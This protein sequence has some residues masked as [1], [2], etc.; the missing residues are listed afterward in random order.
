MKTE[1]GTRV[2]KARIHAGL[3]QVA[4]AKLAGMSQGTLGELEREGQGSSFTVALALHCGVDANW[5]ANG[6]GEML[7][8]AA[9][10][11]L[12][13][14]EFSQLATLIAKRFDRL[15][16]EGDVQTKVFREFSEILDG[17][18]SRSKSPQTLQPSR[19]A[20]ARPHHA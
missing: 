11:A 7:P 4:L 20:K 2:R 5:L 10:A 9:P 19:S 13:A 14:Q 3:T 18:E 1:F 15:L 12:P 6:V 8:S 16:K 17:H